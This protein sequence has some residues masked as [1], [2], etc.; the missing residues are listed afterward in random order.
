MTTTS[1]ATSSPS[2]AATTSTSTTPSSAS[3]G[4]SILSS[5][6]ANGAGI[7]TDT[8]ITN[9]TAA[10]KSSLETPI[11]TKQ[12]A[13]T[14]QI[15][16]LASIT[17][18]LTGFSTAL[19]QLISGGSLQTQPTSSDTSIMSVAAVA[20]VPVGALNQSVTVNALAQAQSVKSAAYSGTQAFNVGTLTLTV[21]S[22]TPISIDVNSSNNTLSGIAQAI[23]AKSAGVSANVITGSDGTATLVLKGTTGAAN[24]FTLTA[25]DD[26]TASQPSGGLSLSNLAYDGSS[27]SGLAQTQAAQDASITVDGVTVSRASNTFNDVIPGVAMTLAK[28][29]TVNLGSTRPNDAI[30]TAVTNIVDTY[31]SLM[32]ELNTATAAASGTADAGPLRGNSAIRQLKTQLSQLTTTPLNATGTIRTLAELGVQTAQDGTLSVNS[33]TLS[34]M[35]NNYPDDVESMFVT[36]QSSSS[37]KVLITS[38]AGASASGVFQVSN[39]TPATGGGNATGTINGIPMSASSWN[40]TAT[41]GQGADGLTLQILSGTPTSATITIN[42]GLAG[43][44]QALVNSMTAT[45]S[46]KPVGALATLSDSLNSTK[47][48]LADDLTKA[49]AQLT[50]YHDR[51]VTQFTQ[52][53]TLVSGYKS[54]QAYLTQQVD[55]WTKSSS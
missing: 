43:A 25:A 32:A 31:N 36:S 39:L 8:L 52:M 9:L 4:Q 40:L 48:T 55:L 17:N 29:G 1:S 5:L 16:S 33:S 6:N 28:I 37:S 7:D 50:T 35:L 51:L 46:G 22:G 38:A 2:T 44:L 54:T 24:S 45:V 18:D 34:T 15:S 20:G 19:Q 3:I 53:N 41:S 12:A 26:S 27:T 14:A 30:T 21:G 11:T 47:T 13:N 49:D 23:N 42:Q 10:Q